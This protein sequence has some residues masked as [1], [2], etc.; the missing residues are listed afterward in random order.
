MNKG[1]NVIM[2][3][4]VEERRK[5]TMSGSLLKEIEKCL[6]GE[7]GGESRYYKDESPESNS[8]IL[9]IN[10]I[11]E[12][13]KHEAVTDIVINCLSS[14]NLKIDNSEDGDVIFLKQGGDIVTSVLN[15]SLFLFITVNNLE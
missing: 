14:F 6:I 10:G 13:V 11:K 2:E 15:K 8:V 4:D 3:L 5:E 12:N 7:T 9:L 1:E